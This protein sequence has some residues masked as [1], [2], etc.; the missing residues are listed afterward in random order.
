M[1]SSRNFGDFNYDGRQIVKLFCLDLDKQNI[2]DDYSS[3]LFE[4]SLYI[5]ELFFPKKNYYDE[6]HVNLR[7]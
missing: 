3:C 7:S 1:L 2:F 4:D 5:I 6:K